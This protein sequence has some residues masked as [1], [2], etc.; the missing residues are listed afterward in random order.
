M[1]REHLRE[2]CVFSNSNY[3]IVPDDECEKRGYRQKLTE[4]LESPIDVYSIIS[5]AEKLRESTSLDH[6]KKILESV[7]KKLKEVG[8]SDMKTW[9][10]PIGRYDN[11]NGNKRIYPKKLWENVR[12]KQRNVWMG[13]PGLADHPED[14]DDPGE[15]KNS[16]IVWI[17]MDV[18]DDGI[19]YGIGRF[20]GPYGHM[21]EEIIEAGGRIGLSSSGFGD[22][23]EKNNTVDPNTYYIERLA[24]IVI[25]PSQDVYGSVDCTHTAEDFMKDVKSGATIEFT[26]QQPIKESTPKSAVLTKRRMNEMAQTQPTQPAQPQAQQPQPQAQPNTPA[27]PEK[28][29][30]RVDAVQQQSQ[31]QPQAQEQ[32]PAP[33]QPASPQPQQVQESK[34][35]DGNNKLRESLTKVEEKAFRKYVDAFIDDMGKIENPIHRLNE[36]TEILSFFE[37]GACPDLKEKLEEQVVEEK[38]RLE[39]LIE[40]T[41]KAEQDFGVD[42]GTLR[43]NA[44]KITEAG[45]ILNEQVTDYKA[46]V[47]ELASRNQKLAESNKLLQSK[48]RIQEKL[49]E[50]ADLKKNQEIVGTQSRAEKLAEAKN[51]LTLRNEKLQERIS[52]LS[53]GNKSL[54]KELGVT[55]TKLREAAK[56]LAETKDVRLADQK[57]IQELEAQVAGLNKSLKE[58]NELYEAQGERLQKLTETAKR[59]QEEIDLNDPSLHVIPRADERVGKFLNLRENRGSEVEEYWSDLCE[60]YGEQNMKF[61]EHQ[62][63]DA[64]TLREATSRFLK[65]RTQIDPDFAVAQPVD[66]YAYRNRSER[67]KL[68]ES[69]GVVIPEIDDNDAINADFLDRMNRAGLR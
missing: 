64:K 63:R 24:D 30:T 29:E 37:G 68:L 12:D 22:V 13:I 17:D 25:N 10:L 20:I 61:F 49:Q 38:Q 36:A 21:A 27:A 48:L 39:R 47:E 4:Q 33:A 7:I 19:V 28:S 14:D 18:A 60:K 58:S 45:L 56:L 51:D 9:R 44:E 55:Q 59:L 50:K 43:E 66:Q 8:A 52:K 41:V 16:S 15:F 32:Q 42:I 1:A 26:R 11:L 6:D 40:T 57:R 23:D 54:E 67:T 2:S 5:K 3:S 46:L 65:Y 53:V 34:N 35:M 31:Q 62:I 69:Q